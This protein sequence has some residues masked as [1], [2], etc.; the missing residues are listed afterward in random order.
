MINYYHNVKTGRE[1]HLEAHWSHR[2]RVTVQYYCE[3]SFSCVHGSVTLNGQQSLS[4]AIAWTRVLKNLVSCHIL[5][6]C[7]AV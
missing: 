7:A 4:K 2:Q 6:K 5:P 1:P 3:R